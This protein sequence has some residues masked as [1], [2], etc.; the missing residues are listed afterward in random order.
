[1]P[2]PKNAIGLLKNTQSK[3]P[4][5]RERYENDSQYF[6]NQVPK[7]RLN[8]SFLLIGNDIFQLNTEG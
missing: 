7:D 2:Y 4:L 3:I 5:C 8:L 1:M 6:I